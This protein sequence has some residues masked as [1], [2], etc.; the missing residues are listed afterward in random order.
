MEGIVSRTILE[1]NHQYSVRAGPPVGSTFMLD[2]WSPFDVLME[3]V[4]DGMPARFHS[5][6]NQE[7]RG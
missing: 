1:Q 2:A 7:D 6:R 3:S 5:L 4:M